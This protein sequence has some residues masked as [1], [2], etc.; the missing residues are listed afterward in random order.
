MK[1]MEPG[2]QYYP[3]LGEL[4]PAVPGLLLLANITNKYKQ[5]PSFSHEPTLSQDISL[6]SSLRQKMKMITWGK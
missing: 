5:S 1:K 4:S 6:L 2:D 3:G